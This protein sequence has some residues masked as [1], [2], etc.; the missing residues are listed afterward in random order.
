MVI[1]D[2]NERRYGGDVGDVEQCDCV[3]Q[4]SVANSHCADLP[5][6]LEKVQGRLNLILI[7]KQL[8]QHLDTYIPRLTAYSTVLPGLAVLE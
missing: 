5:H 4:L 2:P 1:K 6:C 3:V 7:F 8:L